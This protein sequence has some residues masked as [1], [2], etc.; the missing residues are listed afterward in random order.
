MINFK[1][2]I[3]ISTIQIIL[4]NFTILKEPITYNYNLI[5]MYKL[6]QKNVNKYE[7]YHKMNTFY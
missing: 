7:I 3:N 5:Y 4:W 6:L 1:F 2:L